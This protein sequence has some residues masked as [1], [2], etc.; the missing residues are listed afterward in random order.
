MALVLGIALASF[1][2]IPTDINIGKYTKTLLSYSIVGLG[3]GISVE[4]AITATSDNFMLIA[5][6]IVISLVLGVALARLFAINTEQGYLIS[7]GNAI[8][9][10][11]AIAAVAPAMRAKEDNI[12]IALGVVFALNSVALFIFPFIGHLL[13]LDQV[14][15]GKWAAIAIHD[16]SSV[17]AAGASYGEQAL[18]TATTLKLTRALWIV[19]LV[20]VSALIFNRHGNNKVSIPSFILLFILAIIA[21]E[22]LTA[23]KP[24]FDGVF[25]VAKQTLVVCLLLIGT[26]LSWGKLKQAGPRPL[27]FGTTLWLLISVTSLLW[28]LY[29]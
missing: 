5:G 29:F 20:L 2:Q 1:N 16:T 9:G 3:F 23:L 19:P 12:A 27:L 7:V 10:G 18:L 15:F 8:C 21:A 26:S 14:T 24:V 28:L 4:Q 13:E 11:S 17:V 6:F 22:Y 25:L